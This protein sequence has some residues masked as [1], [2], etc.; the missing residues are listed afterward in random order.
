MKPWLSQQEEQHQAIE[1][2]YLSMWR[3]KKVR[4]FSLERSACA[5][6]RDVQFLNLIVLCI[7]L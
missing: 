5:P 7:S 3:R 2:K 1:K 6:Q 4:L